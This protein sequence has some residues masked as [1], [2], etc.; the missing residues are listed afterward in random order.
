MKELSLHILD[1][2]EN[3]VAAAAS[4]VTIEVRED[5]VSD[6]LRIRISDNGKGIAPEKINQILDPFTTSRTTRKVGLGIPLLKAAAE[7]SD[8]FLTIESI[9]GKGTNLI[10][11]FRHSHIDRM[12]MGDLTSTILQ[13]VISYP[14]I[15]WIFIYSMNEKEFIFND[16]LLKK[17]LEG[18][19]LSEPPVLSFIRQEIESGYLSIQTP[20][21]NQKNTLKEEQKCQPSIV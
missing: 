11:E 7:I 14:N 5:L 16:Q 3:S 8:G 19:S 10:V 12:P 2:A 13:L 6:R 18:I 17:E 20:A 4:K 21:E 9:I 15:N 1:I